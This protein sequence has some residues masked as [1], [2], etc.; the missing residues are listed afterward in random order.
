MNKKIKTIS[1]CICLIFLVG[2]QANCYHTTKYEYIDLLG[3]TGRTNHCY[4]SSNR[5]GLYCNI[6]GGKI[7][8]TQYK[9]VVVERVCPNE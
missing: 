3:N 5:G 2:C 7:Q 8:V 6:D 4:T 9:K 1:T